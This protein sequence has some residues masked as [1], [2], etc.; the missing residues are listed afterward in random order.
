M[1]LSIHLQEFLCLDEL[2]ISFQSLFQILSYWNQQ[3]TD[4]QF[5]N[6][7]KQTNVTNYFSL[8]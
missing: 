3:Q 6:H 5:Y 2:H 8:L 7:R 1:K 4:D